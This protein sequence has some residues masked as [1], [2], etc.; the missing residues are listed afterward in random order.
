[1]SS[2]DWQNEELPPEFH[3]AWNYTDGFLMLRNGLFQTIRMRDDFNPEYPYD[4]MTSYVVARGMIRS[5]A[6]FGRCIEVRYDWE[7][8][9]EE[10]VIMH[11]CVGHVMFFDINI[12][13]SSQGFLLRTPDPDGDLMAFEY[14]NI[15]WVCSA[16]G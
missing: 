1:M 4:E 10:N 15:F 7:A 11:S 13:G 3:E 2:G 6:E 12:N 8:L 14:K 9:D 5:A 16:E